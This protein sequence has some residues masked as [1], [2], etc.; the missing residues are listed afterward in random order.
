M[1]HMSGRAAGGC[2]PRMARAGDKAAGGGKNDAECEVRWWCEANRAP[3]RGVGSPTPHAHF[4][5]PA[6]GSPRRREC[7]RRAGP[8]HTPHRH[9]RCAS[10]EV[11]S[12]PTRIGGRPNQGSPAMPIEDGQPHMH[13]PSIPG[14]ACAVCPARQ[15]QQWRF[16]GA[17][18]GTTAA[19][20]SGSV[21][22]LIL[23]VCRCRMRRPRRRWRGRIESPCCGETS[24]RRD[25]LSG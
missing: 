6:T 18:R 10:C 11:R 19:A 21:P 13:L 22:A 8:R 7:W 25:R 17:C 12:D 2:A 14:A 20:G 24:R 16:G 3:E 1:L 15:A 4:A 23:P 5:A 9:R